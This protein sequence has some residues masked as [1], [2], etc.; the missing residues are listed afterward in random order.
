MKSDGR[1]RVFQTAVVGLGNIGFF[2][3]LDP[4]RRETWS[5]VT[6]YERCKKTKLAGVVEIDRRKI[7][8]FKHYYRNIPV[9]ETIAQLMNNVETEVVSLCTP[10]E[11]HYKLMMELIKYP[12]KGIFC[13][14]PLALDVRQAKN[15]I[16]K[17][18]GKEIVLAVNHTRRWDS[19]YLFVKKLIS[20]GKIGSIKTVH[21]A[22]SGQIYN[23]GTHLFDAVRMI[24]GK[25]AIQAS[26]ISKDCNVSDPH[27]S[28]WLK[29]EE[30][31]QCTVISTGGV[32]DLIFEIDIIG[33][34]GR[35]KIL[36]NGG[37][38]ELFLFTESPK[39]SGYREL[40]S[41]SPGRVHKE[42]RLVEAVY[43]II[44]VIEG[45]KNRVNCTGYDG[46]AALLISHCMLESAKKNGK[47]VS[48]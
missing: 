18:E 35:I 41:E 3:N 32:K 43:D 30:D 7:E 25:E 8:I 4:N 5:H 42:D 12:I 40:R 19:N 22:Y 23:I 1:K 21:L 45:N 26:G 27:I 44:S 33:S 15:M 16:Q 37:I 11:S 20:S 10:T 13:E 9:F 46:L 28:G 36:N 48:I 2:F 24:T 29:F 38:I 31:I 39:Y 14:K 17:C 34:E 6:A 47:P